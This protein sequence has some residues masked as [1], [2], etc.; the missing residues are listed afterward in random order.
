MVVEGPILTA[1]SHGDKFLCNSY[2]LLKNLTA[3]TKK[4]L[5]PLQCHLMARSGNRGYQICSYKIHH[6][7][8]NI[9]SETRR[10]MV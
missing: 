4:S 7:R 5:N 10:K 3:T 8:S 9:T 6:N 2:V 1:N